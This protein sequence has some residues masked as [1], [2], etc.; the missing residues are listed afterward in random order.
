MTWFS[1]I[2]G[3]LLGGARIAPIVNGTGHVVLFGILDARSQKKS[4]NF[5]IWFVEP[6]K[7]RITHFGPFGKKK[8]K[9]KDSDEQK[10]Q[11]RWEE[12]SGSEFWTSLDWIYSLSTSSRAYRINTIQFWFEDAYSRLMASILASLE[13]LKEALT[14]SIREDLGIP[15]SSLDKLEKSDLLSLEKEVRNELSKKEPSKT[16]VATKIQN[17][18]QLK[19]QAKVISIFAKQTA[20]EAVIIAA[21]QSVKNV[22]F[23]QALKEAA[24]DAAKQAGKEAFKPFTGKAFTLAGKEVA[25]IAAKGASKEGAAITV[26]QAGKEAFKPF[27][28]KAFTLAGKGMSSIAAKEAS[29]ETAAI[30]AKQAGK[31]TAAVA[32]KQTGKQSSASVAKA[33]PFLGKYISNFNSNCS[34]LLDLKKLQEQAKKVFCY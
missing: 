12:I 31:E 27:T 4:F 7:C 1:E 29:K 15:E 11:Q 28:G 18:V 10:F 8:E 19:V 20:K 24:A 6:N 30:T 26:K 17:I 21:K 33:L 2:V 34:K 13:Q 9:E 16:A 3:D 22:A 25:S 32:A 5:L 14:I 23:Q